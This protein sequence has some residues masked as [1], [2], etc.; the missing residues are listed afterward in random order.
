V[1]S[2]KAELIH[3]VGLS[4]GGETVLSAETIIVPAAERLPQP[5]VNGIL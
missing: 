5:P 3:T 4:D 2:F 1:I